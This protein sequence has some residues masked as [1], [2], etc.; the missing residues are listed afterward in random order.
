MS[1]TF[2][3]RFVGGMHACDALVEEDQF[4]WP[5]PGIIKAES[6]YYQKVSESDLPPQE[7]GSNV[8]RSA[9]YEWHPGQFEEGKARATPQG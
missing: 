7:P 2:M 9:V 8:V 5:L 6:G 1:E 3:M 4:P